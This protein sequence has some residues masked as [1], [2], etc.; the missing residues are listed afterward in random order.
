MEFKDFKNAFSYGERSN[1]NYKFFSKLTDEE[2]ADFIE[3]LL[4]KAGTA[5]DDGDVTKIIEHIIQGQKQAYSKPAKFTYDEGPFISFNKDLSDSKIGLIT[6]TG[7]FVAGD[8]PAPLNSPGM[9][10]KEAENRIQ[11]FLKEKPIL[12]EIPKDTPINKLEV[13]HGGYDISGVLADHD[14]AFPLETLSVFE[15]ENLIGEL[16]PSVYSFVGACAQGELKK[17]VEQEWLNKIQ[18]QHLDA[19]LLVPV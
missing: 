6:S 14:T 3:G 1:L 7:H 11:E 19:V 4:S 9:T 12:S 18:A 5:I 2:A 8:D 16:A 15:K 17:Q 13:R 10:Q